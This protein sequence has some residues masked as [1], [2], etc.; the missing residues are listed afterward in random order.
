MAPNPSGGGR[1]SWGEHA[2]DDLVLALLVAVALSPVLWGEEFGW[3]GYLQPR[4]SPNRPQQSAVATGVIWAVWHYPVILLTGF[5]HP[6]HRLAGLALFTGFAVLMSIILGWF[7]QEAGN[8][9]APSLAH[10]GVNH[11][12][13]P[14]LAAVFPGASLLIVGVG[15]IL[16]MP[17]FAVVALWVV[18]TGRLRP[19]SGRSK[20]A[21]HA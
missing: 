8:S 12:A 11:F 7:E 17:A 5:N 9:W 16:A 6:D 18:V 13:E 10:S 21:V 4:L 20:V 19:Q 2:R 3:R 14:V 15:G 1:D